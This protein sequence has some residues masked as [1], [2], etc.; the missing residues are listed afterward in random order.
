V[1]PDAGHFGLP[2]HPAT[3]AVI[4]DLLRGVAVDGYEAA[5]DPVPAWSYKHAPEM[6]PQPT[7]RWSAEWDFLADHG[8]TRPI[9][10][11]A[12]AQS[13]APAPAAPSP[14]AGAVTVKP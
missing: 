1:V 13:T 12:A 3:V 4:L 2:A 6:R 5:G 8:P 14:Y 7:G 11:G 9:G 10:T